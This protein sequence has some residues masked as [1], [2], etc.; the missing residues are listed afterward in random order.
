MGQLIWR[1][2]IAFIFIGFFGHVCLAD[3]VECTGSL[4]FFYQKNL[5]QKSQWISV[6]FN[7]R[8]GKAIFQTDKMRFGPSVEKSKIEVETLITPK[9]TGKAGQYQFLASGR[10][11]RVDRLQ[12]GKTS[13]RL[14]CQLSDY[15]VFSH[16]GLE[17]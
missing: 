12:P 4:D 13:D 14:Y 5:K 8:N 6:N 11:F 1:K 17:K 9:L 3:F 15:D 7:G 2:T 16:E 10:N